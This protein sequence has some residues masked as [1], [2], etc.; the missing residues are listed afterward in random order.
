MWQTMLNTVA[1]SQLLKLETSAPPVF[2][3]YLAFTGL[4]DFTQLN[5]VMLN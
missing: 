2:K 4:V 5:P 3:K 1:P